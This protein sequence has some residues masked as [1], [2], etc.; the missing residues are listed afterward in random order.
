MVCVL[1]LTTSEARATG[2]GRNNTATA[3]LK[4]PPLAPTP[5]AIDKTAVSVKPGF[6]QRDRS[7]YL[8]SL[9][10]TA[11]WKGLK[12]PGFSHNERRIA[13]IQRAGP[14]AYL[15]EVFSSARA[16]ESVFTRE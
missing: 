15:R 5:N 8:M 16:E 7:A 3:R 13:R 11:S 1:T 14:A 12:V 2:S 9:S 4:M 10:K 6:C